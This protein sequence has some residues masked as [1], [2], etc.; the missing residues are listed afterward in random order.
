[1]AFQFHFERLEIKYL[2][3]EATAQAIARAIAP[4]C[5]PDPYNG[6]T[7]RGY[8]ISSLYFDSPDLAFFRAKE[9]SDHDRLK[10]RARVYDATGPVHLEIKR[11][12]GDVV[13]KQRAAVPRASWV[14]SAQGFSPEP[15]PDPKQEA[16]LQRFAALFAQFCAEPKL[17]VEYEREAYASR[18]GEYARITFDRH[19][20]A[21]PTERF[22]LDD[23][24][25]T[26]V[27]LATGMLP[28]GDAGVVLELKAE[29]FIPAWMGDLITR[30]NLSRVGYSKYNTGMRAHLDSIWVRDPWLW[31]TLYA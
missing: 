20:R 5:D 13:W 11:K 24:S 29:Q 19:I 4:Y 27:P 17:M 9:R 12:R 22:V 21:H 16:A 14:E 7:G 15:L 31:G 28:N 25:A 10:L 3:D 2:V 23:P 30:F 1:M 8:T 6:R 26:R 18:T